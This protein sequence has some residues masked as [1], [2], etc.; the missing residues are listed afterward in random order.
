MNG[1]TVCLTGL[2]AGHLSDPDREQ[3]SVPIAKI[4]NVF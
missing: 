1:P 3:F 4:F 2:M